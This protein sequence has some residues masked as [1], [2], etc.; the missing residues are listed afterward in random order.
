MKN[1]LRVFSIVS[2]AAAIP[3]MIITDWYYSGFGL[4]PMF[5]FLTI[6]LIL[7]QLIRMKYPPYEIENAKNYR[8]NRM[9]RMVSIVLFVWAPMALIY[10]NRIR[11]RLG[12]W[13]MVIMV[14]CGIA[15]DQFG[16]IKYSYH[17]E[18]GQK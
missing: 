5:L 14:C 12:F 13:L 4:L 7:D 18:G 8:S 9:L 2:F 11:P 15:A 3:A 1:N 10:G 17:Y 6:G 16:R